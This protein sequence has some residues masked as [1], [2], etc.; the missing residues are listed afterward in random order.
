MKA[1]TRVELTEDVVV[2]D[3]LGQDLLVRGTQGQIVT[4]DDDSFTL[5]IRKKTYTD[6]PSTSAKELDAA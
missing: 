2:I 1:G 4:Q 5:L 6:I 3:D